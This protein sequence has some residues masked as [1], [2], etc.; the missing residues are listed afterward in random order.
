MTGSFSDAP[1]RKGSVRALSLP[2]QPANELT[3][4]AWYVQS[5]T[6]AGISLSP[7]S[8]PPVA[9]VLQYVLNPPILG[10]LKCYKPPPNLEVVGGG[11]GKS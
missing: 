7:V 3:C 4:V 1:S 6:V 2:P 8:D 11:N 5:V 10:H 9:S